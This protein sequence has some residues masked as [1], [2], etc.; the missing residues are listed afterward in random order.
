MLK[1]EM[2]DVPVQVW[3]RADCC[4]SRLNGVEVKVGSSVCGSLSSTT[5]VQTIMCNKQGSA[6]VLQMPR[7][8]YL[9]LCEVKVYVSASASADF[10]RRCDPLSKKRQFRNAKCPSDAS[11][12]KSA[13]PSG[14]AYSAVIT[15]CGRQ[16]WNR[17][18]R[19]VL[20]F[21]RFE[22]PSPWMRPT[23]LRQ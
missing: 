8:D 13:H 5:S 14:V 20:L 11:I 3:N 17:Q 18:E 15:L 22:T 10:D 4:S 12:C 21:S 1:Y 19:L 23:I 6:L 9:T 7:S 16:N 2:I